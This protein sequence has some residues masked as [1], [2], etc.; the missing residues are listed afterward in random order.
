MKFGELDYLVARHGAV[1]CIFLGSSVVRVGIDPVQFGN[2]YRAQTGEDL[3]CYNF[4]IDGIQAASAADLAEILIVRYHPRLLI[5]G[6]MLR[7]LADA[8][9]FGRA[10]GAVA[11]TPWIRYQRGHFNI[12]G[13]MV[14]H[15]TTYRYFLALR[16]WPSARFNSPITD[17]D[18]PPRLGYAPFTKRTSVFV[19]YDY[20]LDYHFSPAEWV[21]FE[22]LVALRDQTQLLFVELPSPDHTLAVFGGGPENYFRLMDEA[23][24]YATAHAVPMWMTTRLNLIPAEGWVG[25]SHHLHRVGAE[26]FSAWLGEQVGQ[27]VNDHVLAAKHAP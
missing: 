5:Y 7:D 4:G 20:L 19:P 25:D 15:F 22:R 24:D 13:W 17:L 21:G 14:E 3:T 26:V 6:F 27:A 18:D 16:E 11:H 9:D 10:R 8:P 2:A 1:D 12:D 23:G